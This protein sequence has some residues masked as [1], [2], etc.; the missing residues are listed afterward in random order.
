MTERAPGT[1][2]RPRNEQDRRVLQEAAKSRRL[3]DAAPAPGYLI[4]W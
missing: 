1:F 4:V 2:F 3:A